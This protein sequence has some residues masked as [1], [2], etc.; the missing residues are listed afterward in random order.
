M[1]RPFF[2]QQ[3][4]PLARNRIGTHL[5][6][7]LEWWERVLRLELHQ[8][9]SLVD[10]NVQAVELFCDARGEPPRLAAVLHDI[11]GLVY[12]DFGPSAELMD[13]FSARND[14]QIMGLEILAVILGLSTFRERLSGKLVRVWED[15]AGAE[16]VMAKGGARSTDH[17]LLVHAIWPM[18]AK[19]GFGLWFERVPSDKNIADLPSREH[20]ELLERLGATWVH[21][22]MPTG[23]WDRAQYA[24]YDQLP[25]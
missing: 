14:S 19:R 21:P 10:T 18:A 17:N 20:Y 15:N 1:L 9:L 16:G 11:D 8:E 24:Q 12:T 2:A 22:V 7:A 6:M 4:A 3:K 13:M 23:L 5:A 25:L